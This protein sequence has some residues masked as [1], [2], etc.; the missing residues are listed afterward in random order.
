MQRKILLS[1][2][3]QEKYFILMAPNLNTEQIVTLRKMKIASKMRDLQ[4]IPAQVYTK[5]TLHFKQLF[6]V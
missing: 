3:N 1:Y 2:P 6:K 4:K 5:L